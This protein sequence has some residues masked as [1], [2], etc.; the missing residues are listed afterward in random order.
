[1]NRLSYR[2]IGA[3]LPRLGL[4]AALLATAACTSVGPSTQRVAKAGESRSTSVQGIQVVHLD[5][6]M[7]LERPHVAKPD[8]AT[9]LGYSQAV[10]ET[11]GAGDVLT[12]NIWEAPPA[13]LFSSN[14]T[15]SSVDTSRA[16]MLPE[17]I[18]GESGQI[19]VPF[20]GVVPVTGRTL[21]EV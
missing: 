14:P 21:S 9:G 11:V 16:T 19:S 10:G 20:A 3:R 2:R 13:V 15:L 4:M 12:V 5:E 8:F 1:M 18:V 6:R 17:F 7:V